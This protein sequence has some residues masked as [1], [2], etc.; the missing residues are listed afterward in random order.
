MGTCRRYYEAESGQGNTH[1]LQMYFVNANKVNNHGFCLPPI[2]QNRA[3]H[4]AGLS[5]S[6]CYYAYT[7]NEWK[8]RSSPTLPFPF[9]SP[10]P[11]PISLEI[12]IIPVIINSNALLCKHA[13]SGTS[14]IQCGVVGD[15]C[16][17]QAQP[18][19]ESSRVARRQV[20]DV[21]A[22]RQ[23]QRT[24][25]ATPYR[26]CGLAGCGFVPRKL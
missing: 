24:A 3:I 16:D 4:W 7:H 23:F 21:W 9:P 2:S 14:G 17:A 10:L 22:L 6:V 11:F 20:R 8:S 19:P 15:S 26:S 18:G 12:N 13:N 25:W 1:M 5:R